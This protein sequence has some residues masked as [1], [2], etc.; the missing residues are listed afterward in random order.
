MSSDSIIADFKCIRAVRHVRNG[1]HIM[2]V[3][4]LRFQVDP[5]SPRRHLFDSL[6]EIIAT[7]V[8]SLVHLGRE[9]VTESVEKSSWSEHVRPSVIGP[10][11][12]KFVLYSDLD[13]STHTQAAGVV[14]SIVGSGPIFFRHVAEADC[15]FLESVAIYFSDDRIEADT[16]SKLASRVHARHSSSRNEDVSQEWTELLVETGISV[17]LVVDGGA[18]AEVHCSHESAGELVLG[19]IEGLATT[20]NQLIAERNR[21]GVFVWDAS[22]PGLV[23]E[24]DQKM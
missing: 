22:L 21:H 24:G 12:G 19:L 9:C 13:A 15:G 8:P 3:Q 4:G 5:L 20:T 16:I 23:A 17:L 2:L 7:R 10:D 11:Y 1:R 18:V 6:I 14:E